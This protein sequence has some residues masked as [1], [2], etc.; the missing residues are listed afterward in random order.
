MYDKKMKEKGYVTKDK[1]GRNVDDSSIWYKF[2]NWNKETTSR[3]EIEKEFESIFKMP[4]IGLFECFIDT[5]SSQGIQYSS[6]NN[7]YNE[8]V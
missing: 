7:P 6:P 5:Y 2:V 4:F 8:C 3:D 1:R